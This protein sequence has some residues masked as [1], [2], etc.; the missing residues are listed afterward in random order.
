VPLLVSREA[1]GHAQRVSSDATFLS[2]FEESGFD[3]FWLSVQERAIAWPDARNQSFDPGP[4]RPTLVPALRKALERAGSHKVVV[5]HA[6]NAHSPYVER[7]ERG[8]GPFAVDAARSK[9]DPIERRKDYDNA[10]DAS[11][12]FVSDV[13][14]E[15]RRDPGETFL[16]MTSDHGENLQDDAR[17]LLDHALKRPTLWDTRVPALMWANEAWRRVIPR[18]GPR[19]RRIV[20]CRSCTWISSPPCSAPRASATRSLAPMSWT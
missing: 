9:T 1:P 18:R 2:A 14:D 12:R 7:Y 13:I 4:D 17:G 5:L 6:Y 15:L 19:S 20:R 8:K 3:S 11:M 10:V 16:L